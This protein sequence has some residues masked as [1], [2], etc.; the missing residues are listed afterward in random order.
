MTAGCAPTFE[1]IAL[2]DSL[3]AWAAAIEGSAG[4]WASALRRG[5]TPAELMLDGANW[6]GEL[7]RRRPPSWSSPSEIVFESPVA[8]LRD[9][10]ANRD[11]VAPTLVLP[12]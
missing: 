8:R 4:W 3:S 6:W 5:L 7:A 11:D 9:F 2:A 12:P 10:S 1:Q